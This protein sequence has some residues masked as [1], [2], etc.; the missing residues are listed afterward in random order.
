MG[1]SAKYEFC[2]CLN[3][4]A[5]RAS[6]SHGVS[7]LSFPQMHVASCSS[8]FARPPFHERALAASARRARALAT[9]TNNAGARARRERSPLAVAF[10]APAAGRP[11]HFP[12]CQQAVGA[13]RAPREPRGPGESRRR[14]VTAT[15]ATSAATMNAALAA[16]MTAGR[17]RGRG[18]RK[19]QR[20]DRARE[21]Q[22]GGAGRGGRAASAPLRGDAGGGAAGDWA[23]AHRAGGHGDCKLPRAGA[24]R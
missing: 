24:R 2:F 23:G 1:N 17:R 18:I 6:A 9:S 4:N 8:P 15:L 10:S 7:R 14:G 19:Q 13:P 12:R 3:R 16:Q 11:P 5:T 20:R 22:R 21:R